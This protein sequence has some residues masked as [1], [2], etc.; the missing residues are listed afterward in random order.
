MPAICRISERVMPGGKSSNHSALYID[1][2]IIAT[3][4]RSRLAF[5]VLSPEGKKQNEGLSI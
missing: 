3:N 4:R 2:A 1:G 5:M